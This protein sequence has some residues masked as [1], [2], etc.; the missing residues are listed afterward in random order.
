MWLHGYNGQPQSSF[1]PGKSVVDIGGAD[2][3]AGNGNY[4]PQNAMYNAVRNIVG[5]S[6]PIALHENGPIPDPDRLQS[7]GTRWVL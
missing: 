1:Y 4:D 6:V 7:T 2:T 3:C 5:S